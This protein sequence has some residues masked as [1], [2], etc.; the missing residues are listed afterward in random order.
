MSLQVQIN[1]GDFINLWTRSGIAPGT[2]IVI[3][4]NGGPDKLL[5]S[6]NASPSAANEVNV[7]NGTA[8][9]IPA[10]T[11]NLWVRGSGSLLVQTAAEYAEYVEEQKPSVPV[12]IK[13]NSDGTPS[14]VDAAR[15]AAV[16]GAE[17]EAQ[18]TT[19]GHSG[20]IASFMTS[21]TDFADACIGR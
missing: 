16:V 20:S 1:S 15:A 12:M 13:L 3:N 17:I 5:Y 14:S 11:T 7:P 9:S 19:G 18:T 4:T 6:T 8:V 21:L 10:G 2:A